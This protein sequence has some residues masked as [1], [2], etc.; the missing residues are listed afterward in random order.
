M[1]PIDIWIN[2][3]LLCLQRDQAEDISMDEADISE[4]LED[5][6]AGHE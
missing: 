2:K 4:C 6:S 5:A 1:H 3:L